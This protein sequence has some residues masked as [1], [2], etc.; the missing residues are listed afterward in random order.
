MIYL[1]TVQTT[2]KYDNDYPLPKI[3]PN[4]VT[5]VIIVFNLRIC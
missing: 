4:I 1:I 2:K 5:N 3:H